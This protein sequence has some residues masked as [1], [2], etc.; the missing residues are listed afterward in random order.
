MNVEQQ[1][2]RTE[3]LIEPEVERLMFSVSGRSNS[4]DISSS[5]SDATIDV[6][7]SSSDTDDKLD[8]I[9]PLE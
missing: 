4:G 8:G 5:E 3:G 6:V 7:S 9:A 2:I 1:Y